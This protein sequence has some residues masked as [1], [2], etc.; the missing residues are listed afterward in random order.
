M[1]RCS[2]VCR[3]L[4]LTPVLFILLQVALILHYHQTSSYYDD[5]DYFHTVSTTVNKHYST[6]KDY[7]EPPHHQ[8]I[9]SP[10]V[11]R[12][13][14]TLLHYTNE[15]LV[16]TSPPHSRAPPYMFLQHPITIRIPA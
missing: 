7:I 3:L 15:V 16:V 10:L 4:L 12:S 11:T 9:H 14:Y 6:L 2:T 13:D 5:H 1:Q 8:Q